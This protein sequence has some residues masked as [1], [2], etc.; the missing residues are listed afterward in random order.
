MLPLLS[1]FGA[2]AC[3]AWPTQSMIL[4]SPVYDLLCH[5]EVSFPFPVK[6]T[7]ARASNVHLVHCCKVIHPIQAGSSFI[8]K[9]GKKYVDLVWFLHVM[10]LL[11]SQVIPVSCCKNKVYTVPY[12][13][14]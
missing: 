13:A 6:R 5:E 8:I 10:T 7:I 1:G 4:Q 11:K 2:T 9:A 3:L 14:Q 12:E